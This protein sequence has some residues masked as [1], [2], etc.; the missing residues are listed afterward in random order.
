MDSFGWDVKKAS[1]PVNPQAE[2]W[3]CKT[4]DTND[5]RCITGGHM[6]RKSLHTVTNYV[7]VLSTD[8]YVSKIEQ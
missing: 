3:I 1:N 4:K 6:K 2:L 5:N 7:A 8:E